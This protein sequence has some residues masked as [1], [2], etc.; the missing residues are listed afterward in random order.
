MSLYILKWCFQVVDRHY[1]FAASSFEVS[2]DV[3]EQPQLQ[4]ESQEVGTGFCWQ[5]FYEL[6]TL[7]CKTFN[8]SSCRC[9]VWNM[10]HENVLRWIH[11]FFLLCN[12]ALRASPVMVSQFFRMFCGSSCQHIWKKTPWCFA[13]SND[14]RNIVWHGSRLQVSMMH[15]ESLAFLLLSICILG[16]IPPH[17]AS[18]NNKVNQ[19]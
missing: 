19:L 12:V 13:R 3:K 8:D 18:L 5:R 15:L 10:P 2:L 17:K 16:E 9:F 14:V 4:G 6:A 1:S 11:I 7:L